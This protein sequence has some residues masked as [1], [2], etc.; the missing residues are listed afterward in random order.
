M[1]GTRLATCRSPRVDADILVQA[2]REHRLI[3]I[4]PRFPRPAASDTR[5]AANSPMPGRVLRLLV[6]KGQPVRAGEA[7]LVLD[8][9]KME[10]TI[11]T[12]INGI[13]QSILVEPGQVVAPGQMLV[14][15]QAQE[16]G[17]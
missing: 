15:I 13:V 14:E 2:G 9:M 6:H 3:H 16:Q 10:Q 1:L 17:V 12:T 11:R 8:A 5:Q 7:L 4:P